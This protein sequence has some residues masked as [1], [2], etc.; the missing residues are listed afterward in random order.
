[1][2]VKEQC[3]IYSDKRYSKLI[4]EKKTDENNH[5][6]I[7]FDITIESIDTFSYT[8]RRHVQGTRRSRVSHSISSLY[9]VPQATTALAD[10][11]ISHRHGDQ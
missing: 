10:I 1:M 4:D 7:L 3:Y 11:T 6:I 8:L 2:T 9:H 5:K